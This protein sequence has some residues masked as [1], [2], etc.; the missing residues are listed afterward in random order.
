[1]PDTERLHGSRTRA[2]EQRR[3]AGPDAVIYTGN[4]PQVNWQVS[5]RPLMIIVG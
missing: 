3:T 1:M 2:V 5:R 4:V